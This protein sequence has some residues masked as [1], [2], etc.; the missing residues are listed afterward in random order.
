VTALVLAV[1]KR[2]LALRARGGLLDE[3][4]ANALHD[5]APALADCYTGAVTQ[6]VAL[7]PQRGRPVMEIRDPLK[8]H[9]A[10]AHGRV[11]RGGLLCAHVDGFD[12]HG[13]VAFGAHQR[14]HHAARALLR[15]P[16]AREQ[17][18][19]TTHLRFEPVELQRLAAQIPKPRANLVLYAGV[20][21]PNAKLRPEV[22]ALA[23]LR[24][25]DRL[26]GDAGPA[27]RSGGPGRPDHPRPSS[28]HFGPDSLSGTTVRGVV[29]E[30]V[31]T[32]LYGPHESDP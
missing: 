18:L 28:S 1:L 20:L 24:S 22:V 25:P 8:A 9:L 6:R 19:G 29:E 13:R 7:G 31:N 11:T 23:R 3:G 16:A 14:A 27:E 10:S 5:E 15:P 26:Y 17:T 4:K 21:A 32:G 12:L 30:R 2:V